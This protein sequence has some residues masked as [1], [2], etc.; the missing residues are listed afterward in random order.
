MYKPRL[1]ELHDYMTARWIANGFKQL[2]E[3]VDKTYISIIINSSTYEDCQNFTDFYE[4]Y[5]E[6]ALQS[7]EEGVRFNHGSEFYYVGA[8]Y[9]DDLLVLISS[10]G[11]IPEHVNRTSYVPDATALQKIKE[12]IEAR[13]IRNGFAKLDK[14]VENTYGV[15]SAVQIGEDCIDAETFRFIYLEPTILAVEREIPISEN[16]EFYYISVEYRVDNVLV[17]TSSRGAL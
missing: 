12:D 15:Y 8:Y 13:W 1:D 11:D 9:N 3:P 4:R 7:L 6:S 2:P 16:G 14:P 5:L 17:I 10:H